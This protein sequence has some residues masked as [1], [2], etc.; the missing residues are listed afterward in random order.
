MELNDFNLNIDFDFFD[1]D[2]EL[3]N[4]NLT[5][6]QDTSTRIV[7]PIYQK[8]V[9]EKNLIFEYAKDLSKKIPYEKNARVF[10]VVSGNFYAGDLIEAF[11]Y[12]NC[13]QVKEMT[14]S[15]LSMN[16]NNVDSLA[17]LLDLGYIEKLNLIVSSFF[18]SHEKWKLIPYIYK[19]LDKK[20]RFQL[21]VARTHCKTT[22]FETTNGYKW[23]FHGSANLRSS[24]NIE[25][26]M[27][28]ENESLYDFNKEIN[29]RIIETYK[30][31][32]K[33][34]GIGG[35]ELWQNLQG[36]ASQVVQV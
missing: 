25:Q 13:L 27:I 14:I 11:V 10:A 19:L 30:T 20:N 31:I 23:V 7:K 17:N 3:E 4:F 26:I 32:N 1:E 16:Q 9:Q 36:K 28:E 8:P 29:D 22:T 21:S 2:L 33:E 6:E 18:Y 5:F 12:D 34:K 15:T 24:G 35:D